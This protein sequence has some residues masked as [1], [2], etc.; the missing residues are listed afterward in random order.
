MIVM[1]VR[2]DDIFDWLARHRL[3]DGIVDRKGSRFAGGSLD[4]NDIV[5]ELHSPA[6]DTGR[7]EKPHAISELVHL[8]LR[9]LRRG[10]RLC[11][12]GGQQEPGG[13]QRMVRQL[14]PGGAG[15]PR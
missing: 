6:S 4:G 15:T 9:S 13:D 8:H 2:V 1:G 7:V 11:D 5:L 3:A 10:G 12:A 14:L